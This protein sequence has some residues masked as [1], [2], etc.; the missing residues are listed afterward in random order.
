MAEAEEGS[1]MEAGKQKTAERPGSFV[2]V[3]RQGL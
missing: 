2:S 1:M 3:D